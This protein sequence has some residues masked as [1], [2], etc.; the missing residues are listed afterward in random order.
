[1]FSAAANA[2]ESILVVDDDEGQRYVKARILRGAGYKTFEAETGRAAYEILAAHVIDIVVLDVQLPDMSGLD[3]CRQIKAAQTS[4]LVLQTS[5]TF[6]RGVDRASGLDAGA[7][8]YLTEPLEADELLATVRALLRAKQAESAL[9]GIN[10]TLEARVLERTREL[11]EANERLR[12]EMSERLRAEEALRHAQKMEAVGQLTGGIAH[13]FNNLLTVIFGGLD[14]I[15]RRL[16]AGDERLETAVSHASIAA[17]RA[18]ALT[19]RLLAFARRQPLTPKAID[20]NQL[21]LSMS[22]LLKNTV[23]ETVAIKTVLDPQVWTVRAD[24]NQLENALLNLAANARDAMPQGG[25][26]IIET[27]N[28][29]LEASFEIGQVEAQAGPYALISVTDTGVGMAT[30][31][32]ERAFE[33]FFTTKEIGQGTGLGLSQV[34]GFVKQSGGHVRIYSELGAGTTLK[35]YLPR[36]TAAPPK[37]EAA[38]SVVPEVPRG[39]EKILVVEDDDSVRAYSADALRELG[40]QVLEAS[41]GPSALDLLRRGANVAML[42]T[43]IGLPGGMTGRELAHEV[44]ALAPHIKVLFTTGYVR[45]FAAHDGDLQH[46]NLIRKPFTYAALAA[47]VRE[48]LEAG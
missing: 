5:A 22:D 29:Q 19:N 4:I 38:S 17:R 41:D 39:N 8:G 42:F 25:E 32:V 6:V 28:I 10:E 30:D 2:D 43:D 13:D 45:T 35:I 11:A 48:V 31:I 9:R 18:A 3:M 37:T 1:M 36:F 16:P 24:P 46:S 14:T 33:P 34:Y 7:D 27:A 44:R 12:A 23:G 47:K 20:I 15:A 26:L 40:Y 21:I